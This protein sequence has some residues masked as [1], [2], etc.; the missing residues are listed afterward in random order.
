[1]KF[2]L[3]E[4]FILDER[5]VLTEAD[6]DIKT[7][8][9]KALT[10]INDKFGDTLFNKLD[11]E[12]TTIEKVNSI[13]T[14]GEEVKKVLETDKKD[15]AV[16]KGPV[17]AYTQAIEKEI[18]GT[19]GTGTGSVLN[20]NQEID[21]SL[22]KL[23]NL[24]ETNTTDADEID[25]AILSLKNEF[26]KL[27]TIILKSIEA[28]DSSKYKDI[29][30]QITEFKKLRDDLVQGINTT[31]ANDAFA[32]KEFTNFTNKISSENISLKSIDP[33]TNI[34]DFIKQVSAR[35]KSATTLFNN[36]NNFLANYSTAEN[37]EKE[38]SKAADWGERFKRITNEKESA[39][40][41]DEYFKT[42]WGSD[43]QK[44]RDL[45]A[46]FI[47]ELLKAGFTEYTNPFIPFVKNNINKL[48]L[49]ADTYPA[50]HN[51]YI[52]EYVDDKDLKTESPN[53]ILYNPSLY[54][55][56][57]RDIFEYL[58]IQSDASTQTP[59][60]NAKD[61][62]GN[63]SDNPNKLGLAIFDDKVSIEDINR[64]LKEKKA[65]LTGT[66]ATI[67]LKSISMARTA[68]SLLGVTSSEITRKLPA[69]DADVD[70][71]YKGLHSSKANICQALL[72]LNAQYP[73]SNLK[74]LVLDKIKDLPTK[75]LDA[76][77]NK[78]LNE[79]KDLFKTLS[80]KNLPD[81]MLKLAK[82]AGFEVTE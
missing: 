30:N 20:A 70:R 39:A 78:L 1:M 48:D 9:E 41:W 22:Q 40:L 47:Q 8:K 34:N 65:N 2:I 62:Y 52:S 38:N 24:V 35:L 19:D 11:N 42:V 7:L 27:H 18:E 4:K 16:Y 56:S 68:L 13:I 75:N 73:D 61:A 15:L 67:K 10:A 81:F 45:G 31:T 66:L 58:K 74:G 44:V 51:A 50:I 49:N 5:L 79:I 12:S 59:N 55:N 32:K 23:N 14:A 82:K 69:T 77:N 28:D 3:N 26:N 57:A 80:F 46:T 37:P 25:A 33:D 71:I 43:A 76:T 60:D 72:W 6:D 21:N 54:F 63:W 36:F 53:N 17:N 64:H 29:V